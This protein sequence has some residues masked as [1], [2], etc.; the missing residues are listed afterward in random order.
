MG[1]IEGCRGGGGGGVNEKSIQHK[2]S[3]IVLGSKAT[4]KFTNYALLLAHPLFFMKYINQSHYKN[5][6]LIHSSNTIENR[7]V[8]S[9]SDKFK[10]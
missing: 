5:L 8:G 10:S 3:T 9:V 7:S 1:L 2:K 4:E 6:T